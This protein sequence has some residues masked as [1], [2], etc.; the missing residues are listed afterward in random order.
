V[1]NKLGP[2][3][4][5]F[6]MTHRLPGEPSIEQPPHFELIVSQKAA[7]AIGVKVPQAMLVRAEKIIQQ[8]S[9]RLVSE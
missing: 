1:I 7:T 2:R 6:C 3:I 8:G 4:A 5:E 9:R